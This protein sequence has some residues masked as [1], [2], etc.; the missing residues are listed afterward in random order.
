VLP[1]VYLKKEGAPHGGY[2][3]APGRVLGTRRENVDCRCGADSVSTALVSLG[4]TH[5]L[6]ALFVVTCRSLLINERID[7]TT[8]E[9]RQSFS[10]IS[11]S[12][13]PSSY[14]L[15]T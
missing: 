11:M 13:Y 12:P 1:L 8:H 14:L 9:G 7:L 15:A 5:L 4:T 10:Y 3:D 2:R 6:D